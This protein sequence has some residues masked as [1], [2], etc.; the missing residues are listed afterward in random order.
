MTDIGDLF[1]Q[2]KHTEKELTTSEQQ[3]VLKWLLDEK[4]HQD[5]ETHTYIYVFILSNEPT[6]KNIKL[7]EWYL[8]PATEDYVRQAA[9]GCMVRYWSILDKYDQVIIDALN[10]MDEEEHADIGIAARGVVFDIIHT[11]KNKKL[12]EAVE[13]KL[14]YYLEK[15]RHLTMSEESNLIMMCEQM[16]ISHEKHVHGQRC[17]FCLEL[18]DAM[19]FA[20]VKEKYLPTL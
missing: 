10:L 7:I 19:K 1:Q 15:Q 20:L 12:L 8:S 13:R 3:E 16:M 14:N 11:T 2:L 9:L 6:P 17:S 4:A 18:G 5:I